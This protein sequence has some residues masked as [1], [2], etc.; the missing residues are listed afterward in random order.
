M[1]QSDEIDA[2]FLHVP[3]GI[4]IA[5]YFWD[6]TNRRNNGCDGI[7]LFR[8]GNDYCYLWVEAMVD[9]DMW[10]AY[11]LDIRTHVDVP[12]GEL[13][14]TRDYLFVM[15]GAGGLNAVEW[16]QHP[17]KFEDDGW[18]RFVAAMH[19]FTG[20]IEG[21]VEAHETRVNPPAGGAR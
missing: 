4:E 2:P 14:E 6:E 1:D 12:T 11:L 16:H 7:D 20:R 21:E 15:R 13:G 17:V 9:L 5:H 3:S 19:W 8:D 18:D 10:E